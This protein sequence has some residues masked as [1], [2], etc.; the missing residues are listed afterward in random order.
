MD[1]AA[2]VSQSCSMPAST[3]KEVPALPEVTVMGPQ[4]GEA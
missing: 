4:I 3:P 2:P 1:A